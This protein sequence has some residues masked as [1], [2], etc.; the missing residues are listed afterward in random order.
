[1]NILEN[2]NYKYKKIVLGTAVVSASL[3]ASAPE[4]IENDQHN[5]LIK[6][7]YDLSVDYNA[8][9][10]T[11]TESLFQNDLDMLAKIEICEINQTIQ[12]VFN[13]NIQ[14]YWI[15]AKNML[16]KSCLFIS[17]E[18]QNDLMNKYADLELEI[19]LTL[20]E[21]LKTSQLFNA[22]ALM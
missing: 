7:S 15:P 8:K 10:L 19:F 6:P 12:E 13:A 14:N 16:N 20:K 18:K 22:I 11:T 21:K 1:M 2:I 4:Y 3:F 9:Q 17:I 5:I